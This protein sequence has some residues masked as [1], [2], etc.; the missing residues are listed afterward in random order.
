MVRKTN[1]KNDSS[2]FVKWI[3]RVKDQAKII[4]MPYFR[5]ILKG[6]KSIKML[7]TIDGNKESVDWNHGLSS[8]ES[9]SGRTG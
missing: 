7:D 1:L 3:L 8:L 9:G 4:Y 6:G 2:K 5:N